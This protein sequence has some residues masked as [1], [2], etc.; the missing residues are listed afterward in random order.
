M[1]RIAGSTKQE[2]DDRIMNSALFCLANYGD[3]ATTFQSIAS[4]AGVSPAS[5]VNYFKTRE[6]IYPRVLDYVITA[7]RRDTVEATQKPQDPA[8]RLS[9]YFKV[10]VE[11]FRSAPERAKIYLLM[12][13]FASFSPTY[14]RICT[15]IKEVAIDRIDS[16]LKDGEENGVFK[17]E[18]DRRLVARFIH[19]SLNGLLI[20]LLTNT[21]PTSDSTLLKNFEKEI[22]KIIKR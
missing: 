11:F 15:E 2:S 21:Q 20:S 5:V 10:S 18:E 19:N 16:I 4:R 12:Y 7:A 13:H 6:Q 22:F 9:A 1:A 17:L 3:K 14:T 8:K